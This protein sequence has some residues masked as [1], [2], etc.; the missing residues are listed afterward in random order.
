MIKNVGLHMHYL[1]Y[2]SVA[3]GGALGAVSRVALG[4]VLPESMFGVPVYILLINSI[5]CLIMGILT[6]VMAIHWSASENARYFLI[7]GFLGGFTTFSAF[8]LEFGLLFA[9]NQPLLAFLYA[10]LS[11]L[12]SIG[13]FFIGMKIIRIL[14]F[15]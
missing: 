7:S 14:N 9:R 12:F 15:G 2:L 1:H 3:L 4:R 10:G 5:G 6:E 11:F 8:A 13:S